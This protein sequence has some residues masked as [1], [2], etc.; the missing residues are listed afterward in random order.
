MAV[1]KMIGS[2]LPFSI[3][4]RRLATS[5]PSIPGICTSSKMT[6]KVSVATRSR[7]SAPD[8]AST[9]RTS[10]G[11]SRAPRTTRFAGES[12]TMRTLAV[13]GE[14]GCPT[15]LLRG[16]RHRYDHRSLGCHPDVEDGEEL[17]GVDG[18]GDVFR[19]SRR[20][21]LLPV[22]LHGLRRQRDDRQ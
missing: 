11:L 19:G 1:T 18:F 4:R 21:G 9:T 2:S 17:L 7:A 8:F 10:S 15:L 14:L 16:P 5:K 13:F 3:L 20:E 6:A 12:S 22:A